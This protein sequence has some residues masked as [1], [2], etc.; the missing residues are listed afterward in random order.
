[1]FSSLPKLADKNFVVGFL[2][3]TLLATFA[4]LFLCKDIGSCSS[5]YPAVLNEKSFGKLTVLVLAVWLGATILMICNHVLYRVLEGYVGP[6]NRPRWRRQK[7]QTLLESRKQLA[8]QS[9]TMTD[10]NKQA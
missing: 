4:V 10:P 1:M 2:L 8:R 7:Q 9:R 3:P 5:V 6:F